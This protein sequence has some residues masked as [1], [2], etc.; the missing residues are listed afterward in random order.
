MPQRTARAEQDL[1]VAPGGAKRG[2]RLQEQAR[3]SRIVPGQNRQRDGRA[4][5]ELR[6]FVFVMFG[7]EF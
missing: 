6:D 2:K 5:G 1:K 4:A 3:E 7:A